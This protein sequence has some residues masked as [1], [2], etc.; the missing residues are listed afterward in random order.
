MTSWARVR[1]PVAVQRADGPVD[2]SEGR[3]RVGG[4]FLGRQARS[5]PPTSAQFA[6]DGVRNDA[7]ASRH[8]EHVK[9]GARNK[10]IAEVIEIKKGTVMC[11][12]NV[13]LKASDGLEMSSVMTLDSVD[14]LGLMQGDEVEVVVKAVNVLLAKA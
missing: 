3:N 2:L 5:F 7:C 4:S 9:Y 11:Q 6:A 14:E 8:N 13:R 1:G 10:L 12:V